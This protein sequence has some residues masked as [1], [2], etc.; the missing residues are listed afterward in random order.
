M[1]DGAVRPTGHNGGK[2]Y[3]LGATIDHRPFQQDG[4]FPLRPARHNARQHARE[5]LT[6]NGAGPGQQRDL[7]LVFHHPQ[8][9]DDP[10]ERHQPRAAVQRGQLAVPL[11]RHL[12]RLEGQRAAASHGR[13]PGQRRLDLMPGHQLHIR[14][15]ALGG[16]GIA[17]VGTQHSQAIGWQQ[18][19]S[20]GADQASQVPDIGWAGDQR[21]V[22]ASRGDSQLRPPKARD[23]DLRY[24]TTLP[25]AGPH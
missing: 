4:Q 25:S 9:F 16:P 21:G 15:V 24:L 8:L 20:V 19:R 14:A 1:R 3:R 11:D 10:A 17:C 23:M 6:G 22:H 13:Q 18:D 12:L 7:G 2:G 5:R